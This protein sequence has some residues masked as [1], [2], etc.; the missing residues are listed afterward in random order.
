MPRFVCQQ[1][2]FAESRYWKKGD[3]AQHQV[4]D[5]FQEAPEPLQ[6]RPQAK[7]PGDDDLEALDYEGLKELAFNLRDQLLAEGKPEE[8]VKISD[9]SAA[10]LKDYIRARRE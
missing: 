9:K 8:E 3:E 2:C 5:H 10:G 7:P 6:L 1:D 4:C